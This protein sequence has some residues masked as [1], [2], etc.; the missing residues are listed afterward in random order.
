MG[1]WL[2]ASLTEWAPLKPPVH[3]FAAFHPQR[4]GSREPNRSALG[5]D[6]GKNSIP[7]FAP[8]LYYVIFRFLLLGKVLGCVD[9][10]NAFA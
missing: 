9:K 5:T 10:R 3:G 7:V 1:E 2:S 6:M 8:L 4:T